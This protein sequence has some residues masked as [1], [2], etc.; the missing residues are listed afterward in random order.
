M[1]IIESGWGNSKLSINSRLPIVS[2][3]TWKIDLGVR[4]VSKAML[5]VKPFLFFFS[6]LKPPF[7]WSKDSKLTIGNDFLIILG[8][9]ATFFN[10]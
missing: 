5:P 3:T 4:S 6:C 8:S 10:I 1:D 2:S 7:Q 9:V